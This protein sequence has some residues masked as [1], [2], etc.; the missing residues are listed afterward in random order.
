M[1]NAL[2][3]NAVTATA[4]EDDGF[5]RM[6]V[7]VRP[8]DESSRRRQEVEY[9]GEIRTS[10]AGIPATEAKYVNAGTTFRK[11]SIVHNG[12]EY[13]IQCGHDGSFDSVIDA[14][15]KSFQFI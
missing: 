8:A 11:V 9:P 7:S 1:A 12:K 5:A 13:L 6:A 4:P 14:M 3:G 15:L 2:E 10:I